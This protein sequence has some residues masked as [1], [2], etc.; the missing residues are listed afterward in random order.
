MLRKVLLAAA[1]SIL[2]FV[3]IV[4]GAYSLY[5]LSDRYTEPQLFWFIRFA[6]TP[7]TAV[8]VG[9]ILG[10]LSKD[11]AEL[12]TLGALTPWGFFLTVQ[13][14]GLC[15]MGA[16]IAKRFSDNGFA[17]DRS[18]LCKTRVSAAAS[19]CRPSSLIPAT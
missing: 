8:T 13:F 1:G 17:R 5:L 15:S 12:V 16:V 7:A 10:S 18:R 9:L 4:A 6:Y 14:F 2:S 3:L 19:E 11:H